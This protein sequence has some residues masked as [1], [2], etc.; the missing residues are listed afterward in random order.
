MFYNNLSFSLHLLFVSSMCCLCLW[1]LAG[2]CHGVLCFCVGESCIPLL[3][4]G[5]HD[6]NAELSGL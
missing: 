6:D 2:F 4:K 5:F 3:F 1:S